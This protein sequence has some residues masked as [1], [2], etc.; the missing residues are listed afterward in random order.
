MKRLIVRSSLVL[1]LILFFSSAAVA[2]EKTKPYFLLEDTPVVYSPQK[3]EAIAKV[4]NTYE[5]MFA[6]AFNKI[7][8]GKEGEASVILS[9]IRT[10]ASN[11]EYVNLTPFSLKL[12]DRAQQ[13]A[14]LKNYVS[15]RF[16]SNWAEKLSPEDGRVHLLIAS[17]LEAQGVGRSFSSLLN[18]LA[19]SFDSPVLVS[20]ILL[21][22][23]MLFLIGITLSLFIVC[24]VQIARNAQPI[25]EMVSKMFPDNYKGL[26]GPPLVLLVLVAPL[27]FG[28]MAACGVWALVLSKYIKSCRW[29]AA[30]TGA[31]ILAWSFS[32][33]SI[34]RLAIQLDAP[35][36]QALENVNNRTYNPQD[37]DLIK[38]ALNEEASDS[39]L[40]FSYAQI[41]RREGRLDKA[42]ALYRIVADNSPKKSAVHKKSLINLGGIL[43]LQKDFEKASAMLKKL[44]DLKEESFEF[45]YNYAH[46]RLALLDTVDHRKYY[47][48]AS[49]L[50]ENR[51]LWLKKHKVAVRKQVFSQL[52][53]G[54]YY[55]RFFQ[56]WVVNEKGKLE[57]ALAMDQKSLI[58]ASLFREGSASKLTILGLFVMAIGL[59]IRFTKKDIYRLMPESSP[60]FGTGES[61]L[62]HG[63]PAGGY[64]AGNQPIAGV[65]LLAIMSALIIAVIGKP[66]VL[67]SVTSI[68]LNI[69]KFLTSMVVICFLLVSASS[70]LLIKET[71]REVTA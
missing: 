59:M 37:K 55:P 50:D 12:L 65:F 20:K 7:S 5:R 44:E 28:I 30:I 10:K 14:E 40:L 69:S 31:V 33:P 49:D 16:L 6:R 41:L 15:V 42:A 61:K 60:F 13:E 23:S 9:E 3:L 56:P 57:S 58:Y 21:N 51:I 22:S 38:M 45:Y 24:L 63:L 17:L 11:E 26:I 64:V 36:N 29:L 2:E 39:V 67:L 71:E 18:A 4:E 62:W 68:E 53:E 19:F 32:L 35:L 70:L 8:N 52:P 25:V 54:S 43:Y 66:A 46:V 47:K 48:L 1:S 34:E 27:Y